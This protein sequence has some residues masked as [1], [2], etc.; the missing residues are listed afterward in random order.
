MAGKETPVAA[1]SFSSFGLL[2][3]IVMFLAGTDVWHDVG[4][5]DIWNAGSVPYHDLRAFV[6]AYYLLLP[7]LMFQAFAAVRDLRTGHRA[8]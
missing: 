6:V 3:W 8:G 5:P 1:L 7:V 4:R 2:C